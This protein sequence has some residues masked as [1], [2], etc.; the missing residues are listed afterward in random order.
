M[1]KWLLRFSLIVAVVIGVLG[2]NHQAHAQDILKIGI[3]QTVEHTAFDENREGIIAGLEA[4]G[5]VDGENI[6]INLQNPSGNAATMHTMADMLASE[7]DYVFAIGTLALQA[8]AN[9]TNETPI[10]FSSVTDP[11][12][13]GAITNL[14]QP[15]GNITGT[16]NL[17]PIKEQIDLMRAVQP[18]VQRVGLLYNSGEVNAQFQVDLAVE[19][20]EEIGLEPVLATV[21]QTSELQTVTEK[22][23]KEV[24][25]LFLVT[26]NTVHTGIL[27]VGEIA[28]EAGLGIY[29]ASINM[30]EE[31]GLATYGLLYHDLGLQTAEMFV[32]VHESGIT[33]GDMAVEYAQ[34]L[35]LFVNSEYAHTIG[36]D[37]ST[38][39]APTEANP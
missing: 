3:L 6:E 34:D 20:L 32:E 10:F 35:V 23:V 18:E 25:A 30:I 15:G 7:S 11:V 1:K 14:E 19:L 24:D 5:Y 22:L 27:L 9:V 8:M 4:A 29:G 21:S 39:Q 36:I 38:I 28:K 13:A 26:D 31:N 17:G 2:P 16:S 33:P 37:P 12:G